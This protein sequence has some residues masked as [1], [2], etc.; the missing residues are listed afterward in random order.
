[1]TAS[2][3]QPLPCC[4]EYAALSRRGLFTGAALVGATTMIGS[5]VVTAS[6]AS[7]ASADSVLVVLSLR[8]AADG[9]S[10]VVPH[11]DPVYYS[12][13][14]RIA[15]PASALLGKDAMFGLHPSL[16]PLMPLWE[17]GRLAAVH[18]TGLPAPN[19]S[20][21][22]AMEEVEDAAPGSE[23]RSGWLNRLIGAGPGDSPL[24][25]FNMSGGVVPTSLYGDESVMSARDVE[26]VGISGDDESDTQKSRRRSLHTLWDG[27]SSRLGRAMSATFTAVNEFAPAQ[28]TADNSNRYP[29]SD[30]GRAMAEAARVVRGDV[31][32]EVITVDQGEWDMH[33]DLGTLEWGAMRRNAEELAQ[34]VGAFFTDL[35]SEAGKVTLVAF[36]EFGRRVKENS[37]LGL[38]HGYGNVM[39]VAGAGVKGG[40]Y[41]GDWPGL[42]GDLD[43]D[44]LVTTDYRSVL[45]E[46]VTTRFGASRA[47][48][49]P[50]FAP[51]TVGVMTSL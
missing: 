7:A 11:A 32:V 17:S 25:G 30:L 39:F 41:Y 3:A 4:T 18:A 6:P 19:R 35:G 21:F 36:S 5:A 15:I 37:N 46:I 13:R 40:K 48:V 45:S 8:G 49:F 43:S 2:L 22:A 12:A 47:S 14:P 23:T 29:S 50:G 1:M 42:T 9:L 51:E 44:L 27:N 20:H 34:A 28:N 10:L 33:S 16:Q 24:Q 26:S 38:D 31:G